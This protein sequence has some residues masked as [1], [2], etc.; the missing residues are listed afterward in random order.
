MSRRGIIEAEPPQQC[1]ECGQ[2]AEL[3]PYG[4]DGRTICFDCLDAHPEWQA[5]AQARFA[6]HVLG[7]P[8]PPLDRP[9]GSA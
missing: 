6:H 5:E 4:P 2:I 9:R 3:R 7:E 8:L 1:D